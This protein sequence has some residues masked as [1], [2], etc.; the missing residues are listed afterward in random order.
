ML[1]CVSSDDSCVP[2]IF[3]SN[4]TRGGARADASSQ[5]SNCRLR[6]MKL[7]RVQPRQIPAVDGR[8]CDDDT[9]PAASCRLR[10]HAQ[11]AAAN[12]GFKRVHS[13]QW[14]VVLHWCSKAVGGNSTVGFA[15]LQRRCRAGAAVGNHGDVVGRLG[16]VCTPT[17][18]DPADEKP[19]HISDF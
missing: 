9:F 12:G 19:G 18:A 5:R 15:A 8:S 1:A 14:C 4:H 11:V 7:P 16:A 6:R 2:S 3:H 13:N 10:R 17:H